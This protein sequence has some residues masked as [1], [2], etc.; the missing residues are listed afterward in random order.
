M[1]ARKMKFWYQMPDDFMD[2]A[3][4]KLILKQDGERYV[5]LLLNDRHQM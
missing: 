5:I 1:A 2:Q 4:I 3:L